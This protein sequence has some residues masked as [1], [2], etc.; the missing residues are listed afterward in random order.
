PEDVRPSPTPTPAMS[1]VYAKVAP[2]VVQIKTAKPDGTLVEAGSGVVIDE[3]GDIL[4][5]LHVGQGWPSGTVIFADAQQSRAVVIAP[6]AHR[7]HPVRRRGESGILGRTTR[8]SRRRC[9]RDRDRTRQSDGA[10]RVQRGRVR[11]NHRHRGRRAR[12]AA[13]LRGRNVMTEPQVAVP[14]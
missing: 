4:T 8:E 6:R 3:A 11:R 1:E 14:P 5:A 10:A 13:G 12:L 9:R 2:A 7:A